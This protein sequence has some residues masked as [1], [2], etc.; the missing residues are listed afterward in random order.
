MCR[1]S[2]TTTTI[3]STAEE[4]DAE[5]DGSNVENVKISDIHVI[6]HQ[7]NVHS[8]F[9]IFVF[10]NVS[11]SLE[12]DLWQALPWQWSYS[13]VFGCFRSLSLDH[14]FA[15]SLWASLAIFIFELQSLDFVFCAISYSI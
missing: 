6:T 1:K 7:E 13:C 4:L 2:R 11:L 8:V 14:I 9:G 3:I 15:R 10:G 5:E 12:C